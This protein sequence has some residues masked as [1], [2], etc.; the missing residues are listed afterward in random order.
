MVK[1]LSVKFKSYQETIPRLLD[2]IKLQ[3]ELKKHESIILKPF[4]STKEGISTPVSFV[5]AVLQYC[6]KHKSPTA[7]IFIA[8]GSDGADTLDLFSDKGYQ[9]LAEKYSV[10][11]IDLNNAEVEE[12][13]DDEFLKFDS[14]FYPKV[15]I[16]SFIISLPSLKTDEEFGFTGSLPIMMGAFPSKH[17][18]GFFSMKKSKLRKWHIKFTI[19]DILKCKVPQLAIM[20]ASEKGLILAGQPFEVDKNAA[21]ILNLEYRMVPYLRLYEESFPEKTEKVPEK[22]E[23]VVGSGEKENKKIY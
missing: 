16:S 9:E 18:S 1:G 21:K 15:L 13:V 10:G 8:E 7:K 5:E 20:D 6:I 12:M 17:Y 23:G 11:L 4:L 19:H 22:K 2:V 3:N 14:I